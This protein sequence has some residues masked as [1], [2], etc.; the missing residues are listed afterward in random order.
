MSDFPYIRV[1]HIY[2][3]QRYCPVR[4]RVV[5]DPYTHS[6]SILSHYPPSQTEPLLNRRLQQMVV[7]PRRR[8]RCPTQVA[9]W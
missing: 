3:A 6:P 1:P 8:K 9:R 7:S 2:S 4:G 5:I